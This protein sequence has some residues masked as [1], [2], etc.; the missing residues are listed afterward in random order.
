MASVLMGWVGP[1]ASIG[2]EA[3]V[4]GS[5]VSNS[6]VGASTTLSHAALHKSMVGSHAHV[7]GTAANLSLGDYSS[8]Q[9]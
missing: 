3:K 4:E 7:K 6:I 5:M 9:I 8:I 1:F 2:A